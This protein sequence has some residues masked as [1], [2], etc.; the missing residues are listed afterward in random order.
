MVQNTSPK[1]GRPPSF[2]RDA[3]I[4][5]AISAFFEKGYENTTLADLE[6]AT[7][8]DRS[9]LYNSFEGKAGLYRSAAQ[10]YVDVVMTEL[11]DPLVNGEADDLSDVVSFLDRLEGSMRSDQFP[12]GCF[13][14]N[15]LGSASRHQAATDRYIEALHRGLNGALARFG[16]TATEVRQ[17]RSELLIGAVIGINALARH[18]QAKALCVLDATRSLIKSW[19]DGGNP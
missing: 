10:A 17:S 7:G 2:D 6:A 11:F 18:D 9:T 1:R 5:G 8:V 12:T 15:D 4:S 19:A 14:V 16:L 3:V 13:I